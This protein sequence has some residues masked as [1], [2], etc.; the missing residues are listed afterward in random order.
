[1]YWVRFD[2]AEGG[3]IQKTR[4]AVV[5]SVDTFNAVSNRV[6]V[7]PLTSSKPDDVSPHQARVLLKGEPHRALADQIMTVANERVGLFMGHL[8]DD[9]MI[10]VENAIRRHLGLP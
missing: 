10:A 4:P 9:D 2:P 5:V 3:E 6:Q 1:M 7:V 8:S